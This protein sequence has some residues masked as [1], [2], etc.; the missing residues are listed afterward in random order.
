MD[1]RTKKDIE[2]II[3]LRNLPSEDAKILREW[4]NRQW[5]NLEKMTGEPRTEKELKN[6]RH[7]VSN[8]AHGQTRRLKCLIHYGGDPPK[9]ACCGE[10][11]IEFLTIDHHGVTPDKRFRSGDNL[12]RWIIGKNFPEGFR[13][14][15]MNCNHYIGRYGWCPHE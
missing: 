14:L 5:R 12:Y 3:A 8:H 13:V 4:A 7:R 2:D 15:C 1:E 10:S 6:Y 9:C 11:R